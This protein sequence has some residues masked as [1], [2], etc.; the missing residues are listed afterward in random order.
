MQNILPCY[1]AVR[2][3]LHFAPYWSLIITLNGFSSPIQLVPLYSSGRFLRMNSLLISIKFHHFRCVCLSL[4]LSISLSLSVCL[5]LSL[6]P[7]SSTRYWELRGSFVQYTINS[8]FCSNYWYSTTDLLLFV[9]CHPT[10]RFFSLVISV[11][12]VFFCFST[13][14]S[15]FSYSSS[16]L[17]LIFFILFHF[18]LYVGLC[19]MHGDIWQVIKTCPQ[20][21]LFFWD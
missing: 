11:L 5:S 10:S 12:V 6:F 14:F 1:I 3:V 17:F 8:L 18:I 13:S 20:K 9:D 16:L 7:L 15:L 19:D 4:Y 2:T 21:Y